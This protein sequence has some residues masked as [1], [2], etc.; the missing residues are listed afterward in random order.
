M[1]E[2]AKKTDLKKDMGVGGFKHAG[3]Y[4]YDEFLPDLRGTRGRLKY[5]EMSDSDPIIGGVLF[6]ITSI[7]RAADWTL[8][9]AEAD[10]SGKYAEWMDDTIKN[11]DEI[12]WDQVIEDALTMLVFGFAI[13]EVVTKNKADGTV[14]LKKLAPRGQ[15]TI[16]QWDLDQAGNVLG[17]WQNPP[18]GG[19]QI[20][21]PL[22]KLI[23]Y[24]T[25]YARGNPEGRSM[26]RN[27][28]KSYHFI[29]AATIS[30][31]IGIERDLTGLPVLY[32]PSD[33]L[34]DPTNRAAMELIVRDIKFNDQG[35][36]VFPSDC[37]E[38]GDG[39]SGTQKK[40]E[41][42]LVSAEGGAAKVDTDKTINRHKSDMARTLLAD[43]IM[44]GSDGK[45]SY[46][47]SKNKTELF[48][49]A[50]EGILENIAQT[51]DRQLTPLL[52][53][54]NGF[55]PEMKP[56]FRP[57]RVAPV[58][59]A[60]L[61]DFVA[62]ISGAGVPLNDEATE[63]H[64]RDVS[65]LPPTPTDADRMEDDKDNPDDFVEDPENE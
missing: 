62:K 29:N 64:L 49:R 41:L 4:V 42:K 59:L 36:L 5:R 38:G 9:A 63:T 20:Y 24:K 52:W 15:E 3:G 57:G 13:Q 47:L 17:V 8:E 18:M 2:E 55:P 44:L 39:K 27:A 28:Y 53:K 48:I 33:Y 26:L 65:G 19:P 61:G 30:E 45:G 37:Y 51:L 54:L 21:L 23:H 10:P 40:F 22:L 50:V 58:D 35:G 46:S 16:E 12:T 11:M 32:A 56:K 6:G 31:S 7:I 34:K 43:F 14:G 1:A 60:E 25:T